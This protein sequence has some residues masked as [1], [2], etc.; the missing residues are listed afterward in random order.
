M[1]A[2]LWQMSDS[3][4]PIGLKSI[5]WN[6][7]VL[8]FLF[9]FLVYLSTE[10]SSMKDC[11]MKNGTIINNWK[12]MQLYSFLI[13]SLFWCWYLYLWFPNSKTTKARWTQDWRGN[14]GF[15]KLSQISKKSNNIILTSLKVMKI[16]KVWSVWLKN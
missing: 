4:T 2:N 1:A 11:M 16:L 5:S 8:N 15:M 13:K 10:I 12:A 7:K 9:V 3:P 14:F 6:I